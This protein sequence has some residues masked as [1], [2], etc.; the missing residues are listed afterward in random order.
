M[1]LTASSPTT[2]LYVLTPLVVVFSNSNG[3]HP[4]GVPSA[5]KPGDIPTVPLV[6]AVPPP[7]AN[8]I[9]K[10]GPESIPAVDIKQGGND[11][12]PTNGPSV[13]EK[14]SQNGDV[15]ASKEKQEDTK[16]DEPRDEK[17]DEEAAKTT[18]EETAQAGDKR[19]ADEKDVPE[20]ATGTEEAKKQKTSNGTAA[21]NGS[22]E[23]P[24]A[25]K[26]AEKKAPGPKKEKKV[27]R[28][29]TAE[30]KT[31]SQG[32]APETSL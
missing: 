14:E 8:E 20:Q 31:R 16:P 5:I 23:E 3:S 25:S 2:Y 19:K 11:V 24:G 1:E 30:R 18:G 28:T 13:V 9:L 4:S 7:A 10:A 6:P 29:G 12:K 17:N 27:L 32:T 22:K 26:P 21:T 15:G